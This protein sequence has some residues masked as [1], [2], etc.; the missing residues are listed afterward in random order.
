MES[1][2]LK[3]RVRRGG[4]LEWDEPAPEL[5]QGN[6]DVILVYRDASEGTPGASL[7]VLDGGRFL[8]GSLRRT[9]MYEDDGR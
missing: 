2:R 1:I 9:D 4:R 7:P 3:G 8:G 6:V 5:P